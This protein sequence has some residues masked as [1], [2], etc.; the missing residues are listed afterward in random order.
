VEEGL[1][2]DRQGKT[3]KDSGGKGRTSP[4]SE[5]R[6]WSNVLRV[7]EYILPPTLRVISSCVDDAKDD[8]VGGEFKGRG[9]EW[10]TTELSPHCSAALIRLHSDQKLKPVI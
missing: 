6:G 3:I 8:D 4:P 1:L 9:E 7:V 5:A 2:H 10:V